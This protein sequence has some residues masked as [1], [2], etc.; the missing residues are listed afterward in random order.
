MKLNIVDIIKLKL[1]CFNFTWYHSDYDVIMCRK[2][3][4]QL[5]EVLNAIEEGQCQKNFKSMTVEHEA[6]GA[7][8]K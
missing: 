5:L 7:I 3:S 8:I 1:A 4:L 6:L 2:L